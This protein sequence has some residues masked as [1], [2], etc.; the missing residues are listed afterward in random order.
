MQEKLSNHNSDNEV[1]LGNFTGR[2]SNFFDSFLSGIFN[3]IHLLYRN[4][5]ITLALIV[6]G[7][8]L[9]FLQ[10]FTSKPKFKSEVIV[11]ANFNSNEYLYSKV[12]NFGAMKA[13]ASTP[14][15]S[16]LLTGI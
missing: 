6:V 4:K 1:E 12:K 3:F 13:A 7:I 11:A 14:L 16:I 9:G 15:D 10:T 8:A 2:V 5:W